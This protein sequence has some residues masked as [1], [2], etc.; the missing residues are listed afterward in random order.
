MARA[1]GQAVT[2]LLRP[3]Q[4][5]AR[6]DSVLCGNRDGSKLLSSH[7]PETATEALGSKPP[8]GEPQ[9][10]ARFL[11][12]FTHARSDQAQLPVTSYT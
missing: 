12:S 2:S 5:T 6:A 7:M 1:T 9:G 10:P 11:A 8:D 3:A 4:N